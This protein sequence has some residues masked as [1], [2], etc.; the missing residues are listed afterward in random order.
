MEVYLLAVLFFGTLYLYKD[1]LIFKH[2]IKTD[3][4][5]KSL[6]NHHNIDLVKRS[7]S[8]LGEMIYTKSKEY[9]IEIDSMKFRNDTVQLNISGR[10]ENCINFLNN[11]EFHLLL[12]NLKIKK[13]PA[14]VMEAVYDKK[15][16]FNEKAIYQKIASL[17]NPFL[18]NIAAVDKTIEVEK[19]LD[20]SFKITAIIGKLINI[21]GEWYQKDATINGRKIVEIYPNMVK[22][23]DI[24]TKEVKKL[25]LYKE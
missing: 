14:L 20:V 9:K 11:L 18:E 10:F 12:K 19:N 25:Y 2:L 21:D 13:Q 17:P 15:Y 1:E 4:S 6:V 5:A 24:K 23:L 7:N 8:F 3:H 22:I 16:F